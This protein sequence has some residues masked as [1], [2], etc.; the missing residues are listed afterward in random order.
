MRY[1]GRAPQYLVGHRDRMERAIAAR[2]DGIELVGNAYHGVGLPACVESA[3]E[4][5]RRLV[6]RVA[7]QVPAR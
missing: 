5:G 3:R 1:P 7:G 6:E 2:P 4:A